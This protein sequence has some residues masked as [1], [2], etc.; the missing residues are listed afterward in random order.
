MNKNE[1]QSHAV[2]LVAIEYGATWPD[3]G[4][5]LRGYAPNTTVEPQLVHESA[6]EFSA[7]VRRRLRQGHE[8]GELLVGAGYVCALRP[9]ADPVQL[10]LAR[11]QTCEAMLVLLDAAA[12][13]M[14]CD[15]QLILGGGAWRSS[16]TEAFARAELIQLWDRLSGQAHGGLVSLRFETGVGSGLFPAGR[17][18][19]GGLERTGS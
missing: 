14:G 10:G 5:S 1:E 2:S 13:A 16:E 12:V 4:A 8:R 7:R 11:Q 18:A 15:V 9:D 17:A 6:E 3:W 19:A